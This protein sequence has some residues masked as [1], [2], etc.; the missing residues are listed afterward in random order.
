MIGLDLLA[1]AVMAVFAYM[2][3]CAWSL[4]SAATYKGQPI[5]ASK[6]R[7]AA[8]IVLATCVYVWYKLWT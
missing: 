3:L 2:A 1:S 6:V 4:P 5:G 8:L 7:L